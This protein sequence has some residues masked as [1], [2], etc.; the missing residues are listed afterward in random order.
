MNYFIDTEFIEGTQEKFFGKTKPTIDMISIGMV[1]ENGREF[2]AIS[3]EFNIKEAWNRCE[4]KV[5]KN[6]PQ[7][8][9]Y[10]KEYWIRK[11][12]LYPIFN[13]LIQRDLASSYKMEQVIGRGY[14]VNQDFNLKRFKELIEMY[15]EKNIEIAN[16][17][18]AFIY[19]D[20]CGGS[21]MSAIE[22]AMKHEIS[23]KTKEPQFYGFYS[24]YDWV[25]FCWLFGT[26]M[27]LP[28]GFPK[29]CRDLKQMSD[30]KQLEVNKTAVVGEKITIRD[31]ASYPKKT[32]EHNAL[33][34]AK[35]N[36]ELYKFL[37][38]I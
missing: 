37:S 23:D 31:N 20:D 14:E 19:G 8:P 5:N 22:M 7:G 11:N 9:E 33:S 26:M 16:G 3:K 18:C 27:T 38:K 21:G 29:H 2:Y 1:D 25:V 17:I 10:N 35:W 4:K 13:E 28:K 32:D 34:D 6:F 30:D 24:A 12:V 36:L 15:G